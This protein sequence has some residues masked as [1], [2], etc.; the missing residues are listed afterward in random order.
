MGSRSYLD[1]TS[2][3]PK[4]CCLLLLFWPSLIPFGSLLVAAG[5]IPICFPGVWEREGAR[6]AATGWRRCSV[7][8]LHELLAGAAASAPAL[9]LPSAELPP[10]ATGLVLTLL[11]PRL[12][13]WALFVGLNYD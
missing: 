13:V 12:W 1:S 10:A 9:L 8:L 7:E 11:P 3:S 6:G 2:A 5:A 4:H